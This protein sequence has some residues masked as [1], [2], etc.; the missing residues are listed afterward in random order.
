[1]K[2]LLTWLYG[3]SARNAH[4]REMAKKAIE[5]LKNRGSMEYMALCRELGI[6]F[7]KYKKPKRTFY[8]VVNPLKKVQLIKE[9]RVYTKADRKG[10]N[11]IYFIDPRAFQGYMTRV[12]EETVEEIT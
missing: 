5:I 11:T 6:S 8:F 2:E 3:K 7:D 4:I 10:Y 9:K 12:I 1:M